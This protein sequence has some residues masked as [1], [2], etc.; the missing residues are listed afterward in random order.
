[1]AE[2]VDDGRKQPRMI[3]H[4]VNLQFQDPRRELVTFKP[5][6]RRARRNKSKTNQHETDDENQERSRERD[7]RM[8][9]LETGTFCM[10]KAFFWNFNFCILKLIS[11]EDAKMTSLEIL[12]SK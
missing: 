12:N 1:M 7:T 8:Q 5:E 6:E 2:N 9:G 11:F 3:R 10:S 4:L